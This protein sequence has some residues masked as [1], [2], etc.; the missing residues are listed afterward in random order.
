MISAVMSYGA[1]AMQ[2]GMDRM[3]RAARDIATQSISAVRPVD[4]QQPGA[5]QG[6]AGLVEPLVEQ[7][8][9][10]YQAEAGAVVMRTANSNIGTLL[11]IFI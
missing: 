8:Q 6:A 9:A 10:L 2:T 3:G 11:D 1:M 5:K 7:N 4:E